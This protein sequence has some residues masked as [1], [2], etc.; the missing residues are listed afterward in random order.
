MGGH[1]ILDGWSS[2]SGWVVIKYWMVD[3]QIFV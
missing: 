2:N 3:H 1:Q